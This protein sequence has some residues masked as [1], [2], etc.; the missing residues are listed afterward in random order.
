MITCPACGTAHDRGPV[1]GVDGYRCL[2]CGGAFHGDRA[3]IVSLIAELGRGGDVLEVIE[4][5]G[6]FR[7]SIDFA[8]RRGEELVRIEKH[9]TFFGQR[10]RHSCDAKCS[11][12]WGGHARPKVMLG[13]KIHGGPYDGEENLDDY[14]YYSDAE[15]GVAPAESGNTEGDDD[16]PERVT[17]PESI[18]RWCVRECERSRLTDPGRPYDEIALPDFSQRLYNIPASRGKEP[19]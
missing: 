12:A 16:K 9:L 10:A 13:T 14:F 5:A 19:K 17:G 3:R 18:N 11:K 6:K 1:N 7:D 15:L 8:I 4:S 2:K